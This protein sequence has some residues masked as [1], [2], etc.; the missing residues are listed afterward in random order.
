MK[1]IIT[2]KIPNPSESLH[3]VDLKENPYGGITKYYDAD[4]NEWVY[5]EEPRF[6]QSAASKF[7]EDHL[8][9]LEEFKDEIQFVDNLQ[10]Q[11]DKLNEDKAD[12]TDVLTKDYAD[13]IHDELTKQVNKNAGNIITVNQT[14]T[15]AIKDGDD[16]NANRAEEIN[17][18]L[19]A[20]INSLRNAV[21]EGYDDTELRNALAEKTSY[22]YVAQQ[23]Q[24][25]TGVPPTVLDT[26]EELSK[27][28][29]DDPN[30]AATV[31]D[32][33]GT[34][35]NREQATEL[36]NE[37]VPQLIVETDPTVPQWA[38]QSTK[39]SYTASEVGALPV[40]TFI[41]S[42]TTDIVN[43]A[44]FVT[45]AI[46]RQI[47]TSSNPLTQEQYDKVNKLDS[48]I[49]YN[50]T[51]DSINIPTTYA[52]IVINVPSSISNL[53]IS[54]ADTPVAGS[55]FRLYINPAA[56]VS[57]DFYTLNGE[58]LHTAKASTI[59]RFDITAIDLTDYPITTESGVA[60]TSEG[61]S[62]IVVNLL[63]GYI[64]D[65]INETN[66]LTWYEGE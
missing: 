9:A 15:V 53:S 28:L 40:S 34:K 26:L 66:S 39:P 14:L 58:V 57:V 24:N 64:I 55:R 25:I 13:S 52:T 56:S 3:W 65:Y 11:I 8:S 61:N 35:L 20:E 12:K 31:S 36:V 23:I 51:E 16:K 1:N 6:Q 49:V 62:T 63:D 44:G 60:I 30:F 10:G 4:I 48:Y 17:Q 46:V 47:I 32:Q 37:L 33:L 21:Q 7:T 41:P 45:E 5:L 42:K 2:T 43:D 54:F 50:I 27:A 29:G 38:K 22:S 18:A 19:T 59:T